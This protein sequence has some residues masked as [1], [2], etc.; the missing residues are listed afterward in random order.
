MLSN[1]RFR[2]KNGQ[3]LVVNCLYC[4]KEKI[5]YP[6]QLKNFKY[7]S[8]FCS[9]KGSKGRRDTAE[10]INKKSKAK[11]GVSRTPFTEEHKRNIGLAQIGISRAP[12]TE[13][14]RKNL[15]IALTGVPKSE[16]HARKNSESNLGRIDTE[17]TK[18]KKSIAKTGPNNAWW[19]RE[20]S[21]ESNGM[22]GK[23]HT[24]ESKQ[25]MRVARQKQVFPGKDS[26][27]EVLLQE[28]ISLTITTKFE[29]IKL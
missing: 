13:A 14:H 3:R 5:I 2:S 18:K 12:F 10:T 24:E 6:Y 22:Y 20:H 1:K 16:E 29:N 25:K 28:A 7:C 11:L 9:K 27:P 17:A 26:R 8:S 4:N 15:S 19:G 21:G 23:T